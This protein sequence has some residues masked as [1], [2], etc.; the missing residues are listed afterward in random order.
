MG[1]EQRYAVSSLAAVGL[2][3]LP[4][5][6]CWKKWS[7]RLIRRSWFGDDWWVIVIN[8]LFFDGFGFWL[9]EE[10]VM[11]ADGRRVMLSMGT[12]G[13]IGRQGDLGKGKGNLYLI[14]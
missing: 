8:L 1:E 14:D 4:P 3:A 9:W 10:R 11:A 13:T 7:W 5:R 6:Y 2:L 12:V